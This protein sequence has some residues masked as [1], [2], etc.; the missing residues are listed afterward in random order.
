MELEQDGAVHT[1]L[2]V[3]GKTDELYFVEQ[4]GVLIVR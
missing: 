4:N 1:T 2:V 3:S